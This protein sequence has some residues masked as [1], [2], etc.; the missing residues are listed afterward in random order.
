MIL[1]FY[2]AKQNK[3]FVFPV[4]LWYLENPEENWARKKKT[5]ENSGSYIL[6]CQ[7]KNKYLSS[8]QSKNTSMIKDNFPPPLFDMV[9][10]KQS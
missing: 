5:D 1:I 2:A 4:Y 6:H 9:N 7:Q 10:R 8:L 3:Y